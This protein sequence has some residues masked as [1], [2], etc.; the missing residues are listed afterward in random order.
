MKANKY[1]ITLLFVMSGAVAGFSQSNLKKVGIDTRKPTEILD[2]KGNMRVRSLP[3]AGVDMVATTSQVFAPT[4]PLV[5]SNDTYNV[6]GKT[7]K[8]GLV[9]IKNLTS[10]ITTDN[11]STAMFVIKRFTV[12]DYPEGNDNKNGFDTTMSVAKWEAIMSNVSYTFSFLDAAGNVFN[13]KHLMGWTLRPNGTWRITG[14]INALQEKGFVD[15]LF[16]NKL[17]V[18]ADDRSQYN[19]F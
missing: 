14:D 9:P 1:F 5:N 7:N 6:I 19:T 13:D 11:S 12:G 17:Y 3:I 8:A 18:P 16:I 2:V 10:G 4:T 15:V